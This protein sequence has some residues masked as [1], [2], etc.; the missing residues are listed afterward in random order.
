MTSSTRT[1]FAVDD[2]TKALGFG[3]S[4]GRDPHHEALTWF[5]DYAY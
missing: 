1:E 2:G 5:Y 4:F 3:Q